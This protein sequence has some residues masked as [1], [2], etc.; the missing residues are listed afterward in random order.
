MTNIMTT[1]VANPESMII[2]ITRSK[3][4]LLEDTWFKI[5]GARERTLCNFFTAVTNRTLTCTG[6]DCFCNEN[7]CAT[8]KY[9]SRICG[10]RF[11]LNLF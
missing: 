7:K 3:E 1:I 4:L 10:L 9:R 8:E 11:L 2:E 5:S 6:V